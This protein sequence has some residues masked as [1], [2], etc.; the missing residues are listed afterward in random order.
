[1]ARIILIE[2]EQE[3]SGVIAEWLIDENHIVE[4]VFDG[5]EAFSR[6][7]S[8]ETHYDLAILDLNLPS[9]SGLDICRS[10]R[11]AGGL[12][13]IIM[14]TAKRALSV[15]EVGLDSGAD[16][17]LTK[18]FKLRELSARIR[19]LLRRPVQIVP[20]TLTAHDLC[21]DTS[22]RTVTK[23]GKSIHLLPKEFALLEYFMVNA[24]QVLSA[25]QITNNIWSQ[26]SSISPDT[27]RSHLRSLRKKLGEHEG[28]SW[29]KNVHGVGYKLE[30]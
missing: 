28:S 2:D 19:A 16:D 1:V 24:G 18:P 22:R 26:E 29:I 21:L 3:L 11:D 14:L 15:K 8:K 23:A 9:M 12:M 6:L 10:F 5:K 13:P 17:Y 7:L 20:T 4:Q 30:I 25:E 27:L